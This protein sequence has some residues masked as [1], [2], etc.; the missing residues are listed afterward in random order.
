MASEASAAV[1]DAGRTVDASRVV[2]D[3][4]GCPSACIA[5][6]PQGESAALLGLYDCM[7][8]TACQAKCAPALQHRDWTSECMR[9]VD[10]EL[11]AGSCEN[12]CGNDPECDGFQQCLLMCP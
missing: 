3:A 9:C 7:T 11:Q 8:K 1:V 4:A 6:H 5:G 10:T 12:H 2:M